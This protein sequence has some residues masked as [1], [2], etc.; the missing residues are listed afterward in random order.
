MGFELFTRS[1]ADANERSRRA[2]AYEDPKAIWEA[3]RAGEAI[4]VRAS[5]LLKRAGYEEGEVDV[6]W[7]D[8]TPTGKKRPGWVMRREAQPL[9]HRSQIEKDHPEAIMPVEECEAGHNKLREVL[10][11]NSHASE[12]DRAVL[13]AV[14]VL[15]VSHCAQRNSNSQPPCLL[16]VRILAC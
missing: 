14:P 6:L 15:V 16:T 2:N 13:D 9:P 7:P 4:L 12:A 11:G 10:A 1:M 3:M 8:A 5:W